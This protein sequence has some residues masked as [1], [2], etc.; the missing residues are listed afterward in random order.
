M[1]HLDETQ[2][3]DIITE[4]KRGQNI[5]QI[6]RH[7]KIQR[8]TVR[9]WVK[10]FT[11]QGKGKV[12]GS[13]LSVAMGRGRN[14]AITKEVAKDAVEMLLS[15]DYNGAQQV[16]DELHKQGK[17]P[18]DKPVHRTTL[19]KHAKQAAEEMGT[20]LQLSRAKPVK[21][22]TERNKQ[23]RLEF[24]KANSKRNFNT[25][26]FTDRKKFM[27]KHPGSKVAPCQ[28]IVRGRRRTASVVSKPM[29]VNVYGGITRYQVT[30]LH[31]V[32]GTSKMKTTFKNKKG[33]LARN[34]TSS[35]YLDVV[36]KTLLPEGKR[37]FSAQGISK[38]H[39][40]QDNDPTHKVPSKQAVAEWN[41]KNGS[42][43]E[44]LP[45]W[46]PN[47]PDLSLIENVWAIVQRRV[48]AAGCKDF[49]EFKAK[50]QSEYKAI[51]Q[52]DTLKKLYNSMKERMQACIEAN[53]DKTK[54]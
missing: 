43:I 25:V 1:P 33:Q 15:G 8:K 52:G 51:A 11:T 21:E 12:Q 47:S 24:C 38:W 26:M 45:D 28:W 32:A 23:Q 31:F 37:I 30:K 39:L 17:T 6:A 41:S 3:V 18:G 42:A 5:T 10:R 54:Y 4:Y 44:I 53:G 34:V 14:P 20:P 16:A 13:C 22:L 9:R 36:A 29:V 27:F 48:D 40:Q 19:V 2:K 7:L 35:Q 46:P 49:E 50:V